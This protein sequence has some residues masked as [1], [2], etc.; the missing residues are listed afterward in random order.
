MIFFSILLKNLTRSLLLLTDIL[1]PLLSN[2]V[3]IGLLHLAGESLCKYLS[4]FAVKYS[5]KHFHFFSKNYPLMLFF[6]GMLCGLKLTETFLENAVHFLEK[7]FILLCSTIK[8]I[9]LKWEIYT[10][11]S[12][13][14][15]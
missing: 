14:Q 3:T 15:I 6:V 12:D 9:T 4:I 10:Q 5:I 7:I 1:N 13:H 2:S 8:E 11:I